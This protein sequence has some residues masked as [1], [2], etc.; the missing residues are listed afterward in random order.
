MQK[1]FNNFNKDILY[2]KAKDF[3]GTACEEDNEPNDP[4]DPKTLESTIST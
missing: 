4:I 3:W 2:S 1:K